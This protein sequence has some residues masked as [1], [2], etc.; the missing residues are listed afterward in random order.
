MKKVTF[1][2]ILTTVKEYEYNRVE[3]KAEKMG[4]DWQKTQDLIYREFNCPIEDGGCGNKWQ[5]LETKL[6]YLDEPCWQMIGQLWNRLY[7]CSKRIEESD[8]DNS[9]Y[10]SD[11]NTID[12]ESII[13]DDIIYDDETHDICFIPDYSN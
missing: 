3:D 9:D 1:S 6:D 11:D 2:T 4:K 7:P 10:D 12:I 8:D 5:I 13:D